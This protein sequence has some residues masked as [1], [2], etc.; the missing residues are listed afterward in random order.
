M[1]KSFT[2]TGT[3]EQFRELHRF[4]SK[5]GP[6]EMPKRKNKN[7]KLVNEIVTE[8]TRHYEVTRKQIFSNR[9]F[10]NISFPRQIVLF[11]A[12]ERNK[13]TMQS[14][15]DCFG[16]NHSNL[17]HARR[18]VMAAISCEPETKL[19]IEAIRKELNES[20]N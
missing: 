12:V 4:M 8:V 3:R 6:R 16:M 20:K 17:V 7:A 19:K 14:I 2:I 15:A 13:M 9:R 10:E 5:N 11:L 1:I 18:R